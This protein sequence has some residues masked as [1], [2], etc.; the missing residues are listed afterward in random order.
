MRLKHAAGSVAILLA[1]ALPAM[2]QIM[3]SNMGFSH[4]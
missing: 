2:A 3:N 1:V 4:D